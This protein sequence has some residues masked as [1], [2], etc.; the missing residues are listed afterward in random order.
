MPLLVTELRPRR[1]GLG[2]EP[3]VAV[4]SRSD[5]VGPRFRLGDR[6]G[7]LDVPRE[8]FKWAYEI[9][10]YLFALTELTAW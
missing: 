8:Q 2:S 4:E 5:G 6:N 3:L 1:D 7:R 10:A 9:G